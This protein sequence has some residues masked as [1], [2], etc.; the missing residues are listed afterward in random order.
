MDAK[1]YSVFI[2][3]KVHKEIKVRSSRRGVSIKTLVN[4]LLKK[5]LEQ[6]G[7]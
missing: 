6:K 7:S 4:E 3:E 1:V 2:D 5:A